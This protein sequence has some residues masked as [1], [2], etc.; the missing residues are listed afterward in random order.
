MNLSGKVGLHAQDV[1][2]QRATQ[3]G[4]AR[5]HGEGQQEHAVDRDAQAGG[6]ARVVHRGA[7]PAAEAGLGQHRLQRQRQRHAGGDDEQPVRTHAQLQR[8]A[9]E[10]E[11]LA[12]PVGQLHVLLAAAHGVV[13]RGHGHEGQADGEQH[14]VEVRLAVHGAVDRA[15][16]QRAQQRGG[17]KGRRQAGQEGPARLLHQQHQHVAA[18]HGKGAV[19]QVDE[20]HQAHG[21]GQPEGQHE[22]QHAVGDAVEQKS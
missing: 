21:H 14:L 20:V 16:Q 3:A 15:F 18:G 6:H 11:A 19:G 12:Q 7:Q 8:A 4:Q 13:H 17:D 10:L 5:A 22:Q 2:T 1:G 9:A